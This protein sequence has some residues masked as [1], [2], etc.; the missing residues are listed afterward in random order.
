M[1]N[2]FKFLLLA[3]IALVLAL[4]VISVSANTSTEVTIT[5]TT[6]LTGVDAANFSKVFGDDL[7]G[8]SKLKFNCEKNKC[9]ILAT[10]AGF[11]GELAKQLLHKRDSAK[12]TSADKTFTLAC[13]R[14]S[15]SYCNVIQKDAVL[16]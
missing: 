13:A 2:K 4:S 16:H 1:V 7:S 6:T 15:V 12:F 11:S 8:Y 9:Q 3:T 10:K 14:T 5:K